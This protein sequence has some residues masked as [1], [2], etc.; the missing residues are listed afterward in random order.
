MKIRIELDKKKAHHSGFRDCQKTCKTHVFHRKNFFIKIYAVSKC[1][2]CCSQNMS[3]I[4]TYKSNYYAIIKTAFNKNNR[5]LNDFFK[6]FYN[7]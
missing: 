2:S 3:K 7:R 1:A 5:K 6:P 4:K